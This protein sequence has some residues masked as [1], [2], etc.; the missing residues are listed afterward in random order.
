MFNFF[1][2]KE[3]TQEEIVRRR[4][5]KVISISFAAL[6]STMFGLFAFEIK[7]EALACLVLATFGLVTITAIITDFDEIEIGPIKIK[8]SKKEDKNVQ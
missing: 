8:K 4:T 3:L 5:N 6:I 1:K 7:N 2:R